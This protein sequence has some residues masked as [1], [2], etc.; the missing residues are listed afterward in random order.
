[1]EIAPIVIPETEVMAKAKRRHFSAQEKLDLLKRA[2]AC[3][4]PGELGALLRSEGMYSSYL[5]AWR[6]A[7]DLGQLDGLRPK[8]RGPK[9]VVPDARDKELAELKRSLAKA[10]SRARKAEALVELQKKV[11]ELLGIQLPREDETP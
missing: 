9:A 6:Q 10:E 5:S 7:R 2:D 3:T 4:K 1:M 8:K 11:S